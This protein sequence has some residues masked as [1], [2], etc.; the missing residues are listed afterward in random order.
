MSGARKASDRVIRIE[1][2]ALPFREASELQCQA[3]IGE[4]FVQPA[5]R[6]AKGL[7][8]GRPRVGTSAG[9]S[10]RI[11]GSL[12][13]LALPIGDARVQGS[14]RILALSFSAAT[15]DSWIWIVARPITTYQ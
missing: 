12:D 4:K 15:S 13:D 5:A 1:R 9:H 11:I 3:G 14:V 7:D 6:V 10:L 2:S 8:Q